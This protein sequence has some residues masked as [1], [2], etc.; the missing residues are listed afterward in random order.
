[1]RSNYFKTLKAGVLAVAVL[2]LGASVAVAQ[3]QVNL[4]ATASTLTLPDGTSVPMWGYSCGTA[5]SGSTATCANLNSST[6]GW[7]PVVI[8]VPTTGGGL[9]VNLTNSL[10]PTKQRLGRAHCQTASLIVRSEPGG[11]DIELR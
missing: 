10:F 8:T 9:A 4:T 6:S 1:M 7:A 3:Q 2:L 11:W 5:V